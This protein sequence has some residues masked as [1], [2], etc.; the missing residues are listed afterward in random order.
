[1]KTATDSGNPPSSAVLDRLDSVRM[2]SFDRKFAKEHLAHAERTLDAIF[3][4]AHAVRATAGAWKDRIFPPA[5]QQRDAYLAGAVDRSDLEQ[6]IRNWE[7][8]PTPF[9]DGI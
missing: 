2:H 3:D 9:Q 7:R 8:R 4:L 5:D 1:M 6:R